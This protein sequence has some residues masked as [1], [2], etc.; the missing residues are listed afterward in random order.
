[1]VP[2]S[3]QC[4]MSNVYITYWSTWNRNLKYVLSKMR[5][6]EDEGLAYILS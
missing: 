3:E 4:F 5:G 1:M 2:N 6:D